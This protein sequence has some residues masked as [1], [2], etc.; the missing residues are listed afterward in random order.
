MFVGW[1][2]ILVPALVSTVLV[3][4]ASSVIHMV[5]RWHNADYRKLS[6]E[7]EVRAAVRRT[8][9]APGQYVLPHCGDSKAMA[10]EEMQ[11]KFQEG[12]NAV[13]WVRANG[14]VKLGPFLGA[15]TAYVF[16]VSLLVGYVG[17]SALPDVASYTKVFQVVGAAAWLAYA[18]GGPSDSIWKGKPWIS[19]FRGLVDGLVYACLTA[20]A[21]AWMW[22]R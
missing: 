8:S 17:A 2:E 18:W 11:K 1:S 9:P 14:N 19:T 5:L 6:N 22:T 16:V 7:D 4:V 12:P 3:F 21:F 13:L 15:W 10:S 20:G